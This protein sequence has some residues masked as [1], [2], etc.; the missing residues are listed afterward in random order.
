MMLNPSNSSNLEQLALK[1]LTKY[2]INNGSIVLPIYVYIAGIMGCKNLLFAV[3]I[4][5]VVAAY[6]LYSPIPAGYS[7]A[8][9]CKMQQKLATKKIVDAVVRALSETVCNS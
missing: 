7:T 8:S 2:L 3:G 9:L 1:G 5:V 6:F 4:F